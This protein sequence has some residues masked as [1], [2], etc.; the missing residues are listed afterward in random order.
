MAVTWCAPAHFTLKNH[1]KNNTCITHDRFQSIIVN[2][3]KIERS[4]W[5]IINL[6]DK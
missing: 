3:I 2:G 5:T 6:K 4:I 1:F